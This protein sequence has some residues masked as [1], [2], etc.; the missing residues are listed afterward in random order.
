MRGLDLPRIC[1][2]CFA[3]ASWG[4]CLACPDG[5]YEGLFGMCL[6]EIGGSVGGAFEH[7]KKEI[8]AQIG[9][10]PLEGWLIGS[11]NTS[12]NGA[13]AIPPEIR[14]QLT[15]YIDE[16]AMNIARFRVGDQGVLNLAGL[17]LQYGDVAAV[18]LVDVIVFRN[19][20][21][22]FHNPSLWAH[23]LVHVAQFRDWGVHNFAISYVRNSGDVE[24]PAYVVGNNFYQ[25]RVNNPLPWASPFAQQG[26]FNGATP[27]GLPSGY[28]RQGCGCYGP[29]T[30]YNPDPQCQSG[31]IQMALCSAFCPGGGQQYA[32][33]CR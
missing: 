22:A 16:G 20:S 9:G 8:P 33:V 3:L 18:T 13:R 31:G 7:L 11:R 14:Q 5:Q 28:I 17:T 24:T 30:G 32:W 6:P 27:R 21:D 15:G 19:T 26:P 29:T 25:W 4:E 1:V 2:L 10:N 12:I 23:E